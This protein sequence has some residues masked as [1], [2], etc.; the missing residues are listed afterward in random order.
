[1]TAIGDRTHLQATCSIY[2][3]HPSSAT[4]CKANPMTASN[5]RAWNAECPDEA[6]DPTMTALHCSWWWKNAQSIVVKKNKVALS[7]PLK[8]KGVPS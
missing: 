3:D 5:P 1:M 2:L 6:G 8:G 7:L 4:A